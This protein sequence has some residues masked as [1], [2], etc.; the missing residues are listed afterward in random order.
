MGKA[1]LLSTFSGDLF[2]FG[3]AG[4]YLH[5]LKTIEKQKRVSLVYLAEERG[6]PIFHHVLWMATIV[7]SLDVIP[8]QSKC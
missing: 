3:L 2:T 5:P 1:V 6:D 7:Q 4:K 8:E